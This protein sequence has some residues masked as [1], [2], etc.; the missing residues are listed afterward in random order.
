[1]VES[2]NN[3]DVPQYVDRATSSALVG[4]SSARGKM[5]KTTILLDLIKYANIRGTG[6][7]LLAYLYDR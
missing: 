3:P 2:R 6:T 7:R 4:S 1:M 5:R